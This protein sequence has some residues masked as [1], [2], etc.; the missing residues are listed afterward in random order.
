M[1]AR[2]KATKRIKFVFTGMFN[3]HKIYR[4]IKL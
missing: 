4:V 2:V 1:K 3:G